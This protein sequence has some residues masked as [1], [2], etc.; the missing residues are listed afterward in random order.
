MPGKNFLQSDKEHS[1]HHTVNFFKYIYLFIFRNMVSKKLLYLHLTVQF[2]C[3]TQSHS[4]LC[5]NF[6][7]SEITRRESNYPRWGT[8]SIFWRKDR[9]V[10]LHLYFCFSL[11]MILKQLFYIITATRLDSTSFPGRWFP[12]SRTRLVFARLT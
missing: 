9:I 10:S 6:K 7:L 3:L 5:L 8:V 11:N 1:F 2:K 4:K 12:K